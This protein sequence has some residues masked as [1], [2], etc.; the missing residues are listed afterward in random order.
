MK[1]MTSPPSLKIPFRF[2]IP[3]EALEAFSH[4]DADDVLGQPYRMDDGPGSVLAGNGHVAIK[5]YRGWFHEDDFQPVPEAVVERIAKLPWSW[6]TAPENRPTDWRALDDV[7]G[8]LYDTAPIELFTK[9]DGKWRLAPTPGVRIADR[10]IVPLSILQQI[11]RLPKAELLMVNL[12]LDQPVAFRFA[13]GMGV[14]GCHRFTSARRQ[15]FRRKH[16]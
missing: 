12:R 1:M 10:A 15:I 7:R 2:P 16:L 13:G 9:A 8:D 6:I 4:P 11:A 3:T 14:I 5:A